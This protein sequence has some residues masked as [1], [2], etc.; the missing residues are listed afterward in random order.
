M[1]LLLIFR[2]TTL[3]PCVSGHLGLKADCV[4]DV[5]VKGPVGKLSRSAASVI[6]RQPPG[7][8]TRELLAL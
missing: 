4:R 2:I 8:A 5:T 1:S 3:K 6:L 7:G